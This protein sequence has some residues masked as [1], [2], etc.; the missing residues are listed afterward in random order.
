MAEPDELN[1][2]QNS[3]AGDKDAYASLVKRHQQMVHTLAFRMIGSLVPCAAV[4]GE[5]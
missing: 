1:W 4:W 5:C 3:L 2:I